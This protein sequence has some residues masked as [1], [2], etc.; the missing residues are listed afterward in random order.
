[1]VSA[2]HQKMMDVALTKLSYYEN[3][4]LNTKW[5]IHSAQFRA[6]IESAKTGKLV[7]GVPDD[8]VEC[9]HCGRKFA[10]LTA[11]KHMP[12]CKKKTEE[13]KIKAT[14]AAKFSQLLA[15]N[16]PSSASRVSQTVKK[17][18]SSKFSAMAQHVKK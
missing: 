13:N 9:P 10:A 1:M 11:E 3:A 4:R 15:S 5:K 16:T 17:P 12:L 7:E 6:A 2:E 8:R 18:M 14:N